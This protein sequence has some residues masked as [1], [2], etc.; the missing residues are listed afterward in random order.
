VKALIF[1]FDGFNLYKK[2]SKTDGLKELILLALTKNH[3]I[4]G[5]PKRAD[6][7]EKT[8]EVIQFSEDILACTSIEEIEDVI[9]SL[10]QHLEYEQLK[11]ENEIQ[12]KK[13]KNKLFALKERFTKKERI[14]PEEAIRKQL[15]VNYNEDAATNEK[16]KKSLTERITS[17]K[18]MIITLSVLAVG[19]L[20]YNFVDFDNINASADA[21]DETK[22]QVEV[23]NEILEAY[24][25]YVSGDEENIEVAYTKMDEIGYENLP[26]KDK[27]TLINWYIE[28]GQ[29]T[30]AIRTDE[31]S[32]Y[33]IGDN[34]IN[35]EEPEKAIETLEELNNELGKN[36]VLS[37]DI[38][39]LKEQNQIVIDNNNLTEFNDRRANAVIKSYVLT[40]QIEELEGFIESY[41]DDEE[42]YDMLQKYSERYVDRYTEKRSLIQELEGL[43]DE[44]EGLKER[45]EDSDDEDKLKELGDTI[46]D[47]EK[48]IE[49]LQTQIDNIDTNI[50]EE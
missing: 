7:I 8:D 28:Q 34:I 45:K 14:A 16:E 17:P 35:S 15:Y 27:E 3:T 26:E 44:L 6:F 43:E 49:A 31:K 38:A 18:G 21:L 24:R 50:R 23:Q 29:Y 47:T 11:I 42:N 33:I 41:K 30:K 9:S 1:E 22:K 13:K 2:N 37:F 32:A 48:E 19:F 5:K 10:E 39:T 40:N 20:V 36:Q 25:L 46:N 4:L 12:E